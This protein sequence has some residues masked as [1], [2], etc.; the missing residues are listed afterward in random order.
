MA[1][2]TPGAGGIED[3]ADL[4]RARHLRREERPVAPE[5]DQGE[6]ARVAPALDGDGAHRAGH[7]R[8]AQE[9][10]AVG[11]IRHVDAEGRGDLRGHGPARLLRVEAEAAGQPLGMQITEGHV[12]VGEGDLEPA[13]VV[14]DGPGHRPRASR[15]DVERSRAVHA[16]DAAAAR[17]HLRDVDGGHA[18]EEARRPC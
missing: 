18:E 13:L 12:G 6:V 10:D 5:G 17:A 3:G 15:T 8:A 9:V 11:G 4:E 2:N 14:A 16:H 1:L 7:A